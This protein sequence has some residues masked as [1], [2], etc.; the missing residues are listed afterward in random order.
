MHRR[1]LAAI[2]GEGGMPR[3]SLIF[4]FA[5][6]AAA[7]GCVERR[8]T[9]RTDPPNALVVLDGQEIGFSPVSVPFHYNGVRQIKLVKDGYETQVINQRIAPKWYTTPGLDF[10]AEVLIPWRIRDERD[11]MYSLP[12]KVMVPQDQLIER[13]RE[14]RQAA[15]NPPPKAL[16]RAKLDANGDPLEPAPQ[17]ARKPSRQE[18]EPVPPRTADAGDETVR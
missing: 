14:V 5:L 2:A 10:V 11:Y 18:R 9:V 6:V 1:A 17:I 13:A 12:P 15:L 8:M 16:E 7:S 4:V 3:R